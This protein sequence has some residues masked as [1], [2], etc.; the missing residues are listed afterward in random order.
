MEKNSPFREN[1]ESCNLK[2]G[3]YK[4]KGVSYQFEELVILTTNISD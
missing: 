1:C 2:K 4:D 3:I